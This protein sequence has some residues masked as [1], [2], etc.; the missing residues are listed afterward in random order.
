MRVFSI[1]AT[2]QVD[3][4]EDV[5][6]MG[7]PIINCKVTPFSNCFDFWA[8]SASDK[9]REQFHQFL[10]GEAIVCEHNSIDVLVPHVTY[11]P[12]D[13]SMDELLQKRPQF[14]FDARLADY[15]VDVSNLPGTVKVKKVALNYPRDKDPF[16]KYTISFSTCLQ[17]NPKIPDLA[18]EEIE[19]HFHFDRGLDDYSVS[20]LQA[21][22]AYVQA[23]DKY[24]VSERSGFMAPKPRSCKDME[25]FFESDIEQSFSPDMYS[26][27]RMAADFAESAED[28]E[29]FS[30]LRSM[31]F[32]AGTPN[33]VQYRAE[34]G[35]SLQD[36][37]YEITVLI[38]NTDSVYEHLVY[39]IR[40]GT[41]A[42]EEY[43]REWEALGFIEELSLEQ[44]LFSVSVKKRSTELDEP[45]KDWFLQ[46]SPAELARQVVFYLRSVF[47][48]ANAVAN[49][50][51]TLITRS[52]YG[53]SED[54]LRIG[55]ARRIVELVKI[56]PADYADYYMAP[57]R[58]LAHYYIA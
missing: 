55:L 23:P 3:F 39:D 50:I 29:I 5:D 36:G 56:S 14:F 22:K 48:F 6:Q 19:R 18:P 42:C 41:A 30:G 11:D 46:T 21:L 8:S 38:P 12:Q 16:K 15:K 51:D 10:D 43:L 25:R 13:I 52:D 53:C 1:K 44:G 58:T 37:H 20:R 33:K 28:R 24:A 9:E 31:S 2:I 40:K 34:I 7:W 26:I 54:D 45:Y 57:V 17:F 47:R 32:T 49:F 4:L 27:C 35:N